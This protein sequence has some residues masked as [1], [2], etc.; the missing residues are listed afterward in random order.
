M[1]DDPA[2]AQLRALLER[3]AVALERL[4]P[5]SAP[6]ADPGDGDALLWDGARLARVAARPAQPLQLLV[7]IDAQA[8]RL[9]EAFRRHAAGL[10]AHD[11]LLWGARGSGKSALVHA[12]RAAVVATGADLPLVAVGAPVLPTLPEL[13]S[14]LGRMPRRFLLFVDDLAIDSAA[15]AEARTLRSLLDGGVSARPDNCRLVVTS[16]HRHLWADAVT[17]AP[18]PMAPR[19]AAEDRLALAD[20]FGLVLAFHATSQADYLAMVEGYARHYGLPFEPADALAWAQGRGA[21]SGRVAWQ[22]VE[23]LAG[24][25]GVRL[26]CGVQARAAQA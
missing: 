19:D 9:A 16:N 24:R 4:M 7:G 11:A 18:D 13:F 1:S 15:H 10:P 5:A 21:R 2:S 14:R 26:E 23:E 17:G 6:P 3:V 22:Y 8:A 12:A 25:A 20:R